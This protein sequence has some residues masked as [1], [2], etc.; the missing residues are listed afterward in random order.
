MISFENKSIEKL[1][2]KLYDKNYL[3]L[4]HDIFK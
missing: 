2:T 4:A 3:I 1:R